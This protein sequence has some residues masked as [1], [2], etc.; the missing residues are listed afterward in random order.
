M[1]KKYFSQ[2]LNNLAFHLGPVQPPGGEGSP[3][4]E[5]P[6]RHM[7]GA[8]AVKTKFKLR[9]LLTVCLILTESKKQEQ[10]ESI[11]N[12]K[13]RFLTQSNKLIFKF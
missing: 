9:I 7:F 5:I 1:K 10:L 11:F 2:N 3:L 12:F 8:A 6:G 13:C 4:E